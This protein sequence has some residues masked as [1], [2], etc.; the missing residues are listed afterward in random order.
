MPQ[1]I[2]MLG[3]VDRIALPIRRLPWSGCGLWSGELAFSST[4]PHSLWVSL[5]L[6]VFRELLGRIGS[7]LRNPVLGWGDISVTKVLAM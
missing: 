6:E 2:M 1:L 7:P 3:A 4:L 5:P